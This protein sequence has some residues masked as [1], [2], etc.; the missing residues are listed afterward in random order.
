M[1]IKTYKTHLISSEDSLYDLLDTYVPT[2]SEK[3][4]LVITSKIISLLEGSFIPKNEVS[5][6]L[7]LIKSSAD[8]YLDD[9]GISTLTIKNHLLI[10][11]AGIDESNGKD[12]Y[13]LYP[14]DP[15][16]SAEE[17]W[18]Y[19]RK[20]DQRKEIGVLI[21]DSHTTPLRRG[22]IGA[23]LGWCGFR[24]L[25]NYIGKPD[26]FGVPLAVTQVNLIDSLSASAVLCMGEGDEQTPFALIT[27]APKVEFENNPPQRDDVEFFYVKIEN[28]LYSPL[29][30]KNL[31]IFQ[32]P[33][34]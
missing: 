32:E 7:D 12:I 4:I 3:E 10:P 24:P 30:K 20:R 5:S 23:G 28:D 1:Q 26:C 31:W 2:P 8:A 21:T 11:A 22:V 15:Q 13:I 16:K 25:Y 19:L 29:F 14:K 27:G 6:K 17:I 18:N 33:K 9:S 34:V